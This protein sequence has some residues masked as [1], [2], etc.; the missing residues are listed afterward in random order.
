MVFGVLV[1]VLVLALVPGSASPMSVLVLVAKEAAAI[2]ESGHISTS[3]N[4]HD[5]GALM[6]LTVFLVCA[7]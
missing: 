7:V 5:A 3:L 2:D 4:M 1:L 6:D